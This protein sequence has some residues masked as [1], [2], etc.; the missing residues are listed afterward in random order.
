MSMETL[1]LL[2]S[3]IEATEDL[4]S[5][6]RTMKALSTANIRQYER[7]A[8]SLARYNHTVRLGLHVALRDRPAA[9]VA[10]RS[11]E[12]V[13][14]AVVLG[15][16]HGLCG[17]FNE[18]I[19]GHAID[20]MRRL[21][22]STRRCLTLVVGTRAAMRLET[23][24]WDVDAHFQLPGS[25]SGITAIVGTI[26]VKIEE[27]QREQGVTR[28]RVFH[29]RRT[30]AATA[31]PRTVE[32]LP[33]DLRDF[34]TLVERRWPSRV[35][36]IFTMQSD[37]LLSSLIR[38]HLFVSLFRACAESMSSEHA[39]RLVSMQAAERNIEERLDEMTAELRRRRQEAITTE[40]LD[41]LS[42]VEA[43]RSA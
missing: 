40:I 42:G 8:A 38:Q 10:A 29:N 12:H 15:S 39:S 41:I 24:R 30:D 31:V 35:L 22:N 28:V 43:Q 7:A 17:R 13:S 1:D 18:L 20:E 26:L 33:V 19:T 27:W 5:I 2:R 21:A 23:L 9:P 16:D 25:A 34:R 37:R 36:P 14:A 3:R 6:V 11:H 32:L 4:Q